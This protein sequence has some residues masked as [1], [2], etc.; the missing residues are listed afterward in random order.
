VFDAD[1]RSRKRIVAFST[2]AARTS[3]QPLGVN[4]LLG[5]RGSIGHKEDAIV[6]SFEMPGDL[7]RLTLDDLVSLVKRLVSARPAASP[8]TLGS[9]GATRLHVTT[10]LAEVS[11]RLD[12]STDKTQKAI[13]FD[14][15]RQ[16]RD[17]LSQDDEGSSG[18]R[19]CMCSTVIDESKRS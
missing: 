5:Y 14:L 13:L 1:R 10:V 19:Y 2:R 15:H 11:D 12:A 9:G 17:C 16:L 4:W 3:L 18:M 8:L 7:K 6:T